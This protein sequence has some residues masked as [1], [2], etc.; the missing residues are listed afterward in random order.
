V[1]LAIDGVIRQVVEAANGGIFVPP[2]DAVALAEAIRRLADDPQ[3]GR[4]MGLNARRYVEAH[5][6]R[7]AL[8]R[9]L[10]ELLQ[11]MTR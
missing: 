10:E 3:A 11:G 8:A 9:R 4:T 2:G 6:D 5:F 1:V 7:P